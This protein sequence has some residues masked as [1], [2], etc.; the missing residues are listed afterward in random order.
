MPWGRLDDKFWSHPKVLAAGNEAIGVFARLVSYCCDQGTE[1]VVSEHIAWMVGGKDMLTAVGKLVDVGL[2]E[3]APGGGWRVHDFGE[4]NPTA[5]AA[6]KRREELSQ[7]RREAGKKGAAERWQPDG[8]PM[9]TDG[10]TDGKTDRAVDGKKDGKTPVVSTVADGK[11]VANPSRARASDSPSPSHS[12]TQETHTSRARDP[13]PNLTA[14]GVIAVLRQRANRAFNLGG[15]GDTSAMVEL[16]RIVMDLAMGDPPRTLTDY[17]TLADYAAAGGLAWYD[18]GKPG[19][20]LLLAKGKLGELLEEALEWNAGGR[21]PPE[22]RAS[23]TA[24]L[25]APAPSPPRPA[26]S[27]IRPHAPADHS[28]PEAAR[29]AR[30][31]LALGARP[32]NEAGT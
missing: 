17:Y 7:K 9:A 1:G 10:K 30:E 15:F 32:T 8:N 24:E 28:P 4:W 19:M 5:T 22:R 29:K 6:A 2:L 14:D 3:V 23:K 25:K 13:D 11:H 31:A 12:H 18:Q 20:R 16:Q 21:K 27:I 26:P